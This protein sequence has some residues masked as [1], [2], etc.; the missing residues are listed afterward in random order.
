[1]IFQ[2]LTVSCD[3]CTAVLEHDVAVDTIRVRDTTDS[4]Y[5]VYV[6]DAYAEALPG[7]WKISYGEHHCPACVIINKL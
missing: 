6:I 7:G 4:C 3:K 5:T 1:M 2:T